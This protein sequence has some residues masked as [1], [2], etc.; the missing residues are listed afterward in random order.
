V[1]GK[2][3]ITEAAKVLPALNPALRL[4]AAEE[5]EKVAVRLSTSKLGSKRKIY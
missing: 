4:K 5:R 3:V 2:S 1:D